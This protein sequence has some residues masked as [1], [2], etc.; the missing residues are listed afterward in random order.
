MR[1]KRNIEKPQKHVVIIYVF[2]IY[3]WNSG[4]KLGALSYELAKNWTIFTIIYKGVWKTLDFLQQL[5][6]DTPCKDFWGRGAFH[7]NSNLVVFALR[8]MQLHISWSFVWGEGRGGGG[9]MQ[10]DWKGEMRD[11]LFHKLC[12]R[13]N[14]I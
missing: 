6:L 9:G 10:H 2:I 3:T 1:W 11:L 14:F 7:I 12:V 8:A 4:Q 5:R 13:M